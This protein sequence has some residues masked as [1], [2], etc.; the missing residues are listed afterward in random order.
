MLTIAFQNVLAYNLL[1]TITLLP[2]I[3]NWLWRSCDV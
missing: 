1:V 3:N 2:S